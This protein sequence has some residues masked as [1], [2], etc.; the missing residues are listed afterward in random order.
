MNWEAVGAVGE[1]I[2]AIGLF[3]SIFYLAVQVNQQNEIT[4]AHFGFSLSQRLY[5]RF[6]K[7]AQDPK[8]CELL[9]RDLSNTELDGPERWQAGMY[10]NTLF[11]DIFDTYDKIEIGMADKI[12]LQMRMNLLKSGIMKLDQAKMLW[13][14]WKPT[15]PTQFIQWFENEVFDGEDITEFNLSESRHSTGVIR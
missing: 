14:L 11:V 4:R 8:F 3:V 10:I 5:D 2:G 1:L 15:R 9:S 7:T 6:F 12:Q 13:N